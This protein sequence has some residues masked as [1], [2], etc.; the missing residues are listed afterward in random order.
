MS[1]PAPEVKYSSVSVEGLEVFFDADSPNIALP[2]SSSVQDQTDPGSRSVQD[3]PKLKHPIS[4][5]EAARLLNISANAV[6]KRLR[7]GSLKGEKTPGKYKDEW[8]VEGAELIQ[9]LNVEIASVQDSPSPV[10]EESCSV[11][12]QTD[13]GSRSVQDS[14]ESLTQLVEL[15]E[16]QALKLEVAAGQIGYLQAQLETQTKLLEIRDEQ[17]KLLTDSQHR[18]AWWSQFCAWFMGSKHE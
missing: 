2:E 8:L 1:E 14:P 17:I 4:V 12:D 9:V 6:C 5:D 15:V 3:S 11:Q 10:A 16:K 13:Q 7:K 18:K